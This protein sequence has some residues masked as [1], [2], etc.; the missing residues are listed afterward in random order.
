MISFLIP[1]LPNGDEY[2]ERACK[3]ILG[4]LAIDWHEPDAEI[5]IG[6]IEPFNRSAARNQ[7][8]KRADGDI[9]VFVDADS[10]VPKHQIREALSLAE[11]RGWAFPYDHYCSMTE[12]GT[13]NFIA[14]AALPD[15][16]SWGTDMFDRDYY[17]FIFPS[18]DTP[19]PAVGGCV[20]VTRAAFE[21]VGG[22]DERFIGWGEEDRA[23]MLALDTLVNAE[24][25]VS[26]NIFHLWHE[27]PEEECFAQPNF[28]DNRK[29]CNRYR[30]ACGNLQMMR[31]LIAERN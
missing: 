14:G 3:Y 10:F 22:Y 30:E 18:K 1:Y 4:A 7:A 5:I 29:L 12:M 31:E 6:G 27:H 24:H 26:G 17:E 23:F 20:V 9:L 13:E 19:E 11:E 21:T 16:L 8:A 2:R 15:P 28:S 25:R